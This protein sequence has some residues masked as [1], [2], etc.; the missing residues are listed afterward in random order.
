MI[1][2]SCLEHF[3]YII[4][5]FC[6]SQWNI[7]AAS[8]IKTCY[9]KRFVFFCIVSLP[10]GFLSNE[11]LPPWNA[12]NVQYILSLLRLLM[13]LCVTKFSRMHKINLW[14][15]IF[16]KRYDI[17]MQADHINSFSD[18]FLLQILLCSFLNTWILS[19]L[20]YSYSD[21]HSVSSARFTSLPHSKN[22]E[23]S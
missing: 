8:S 19:H 10:V 5:Y 20:S 4:K 22:K 6:P 15:T 17:H 2:A 18:G 14:Q 1:R 7:T 23:T 12:I 13:K 11:W 9:H 16:L 3:S 21:F